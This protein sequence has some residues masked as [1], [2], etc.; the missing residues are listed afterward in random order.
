VPNEVSPDSAA[1]APKKKKKKQSIAAMQQELRDIAAPADAPEKPPV[2]FKK[3][4]L[5]VGLMVAAVWIV[6]IVFVRWTVIPIYV[7]A[8]L[9]VLA[10]GAGVW[11]VR[12]VNRS[13]ELGALLRSAGQTEEGRK[14]ALRKLETDFKKGDVQ[15]TIARAQLQM[16]EDPRQALATL[17]TVDLNKQLTPLADQVRCLRATIHLQLGETQEARLLVDKMELGKQQDVK[18][19]AMFA[20]VAGEAWG[21]TGQAK[22][23]VELLELYNP[24]DPEYAEMRVQMWRARAFAAAG[25]SDMKGAGRALRK[26]A[27]VSPQLL[28]M[29]VS[30]KRVH[31]LLQQEA[32]QLF[33][34]S[35]AVPRKMVR[36]KL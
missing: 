29:F 3:V 11:V 34:R 19:R 13:R 15:A 27:E 32:K 21:R 31:P 17:E 20:A 4:F 26:L 9:T 25:A 23:A 12:W 7:A 6:A 5:R 16:Q 22:K 33:M 18:T 24:E 1:L 30:G 2:D 10:I 8:G 28:G 36:Q 35:G 14:E